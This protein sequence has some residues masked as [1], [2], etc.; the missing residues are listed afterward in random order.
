[1]VVVLPEPLTPTTRMTKGLSALDGERLGDR[2]EHLLDFGG[3]HRLHLV[4]R[5]RLVV[6]ALADRGGDAA[7]RQSTPRS[8][9]IS[10]SS[11][12]SS[13]SLVEL[14]L[15]ITRSAIAPP[16]DVREVRLSPPLSRCHQLRSFRAVVHAGS[17]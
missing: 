15:G 5:D 14:A 3:E 10:T 9:R 6:A 11:I 16:T 2:R 7:P 8:A 17:P 1:M 12:S 13:M 4:R